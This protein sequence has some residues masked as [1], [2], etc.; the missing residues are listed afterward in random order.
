MSKF[1]E[2]KYED[3]SDAFQKAVKNANK[4]KKGLLIIGKT[5]VGKTHALYALANKKQLRVDNFVELL[6]EFRDYIRMGNY[7]QN[8]KDYTARPFSFIDD[9]GAEK[10]SDFVFE[11]LYLLVNRVYEKGD[12]AKLAI[13][14]NLTIEQMREKY[15]DRIVSRL[16]EMCAV[17]EIDGDDRRLK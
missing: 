3:L 10:V 12:Q 2:A 8:I 6:I 15:G 17:V 11:F 13:T 4:E 7:Y 1:K 5:G 9:L 16:I 14:S